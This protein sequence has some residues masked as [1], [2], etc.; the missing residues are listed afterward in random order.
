MLECTCGCTMELELVDQIW[1][2]KFGLK[3]SLKQWQCGYEDLLQL[4]NLPML[5]ARR[6]RLKLCL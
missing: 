3:V 1:N 4:A 2:Y 6:K 5:A